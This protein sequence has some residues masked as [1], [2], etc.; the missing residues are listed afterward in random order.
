MQALGF[1]RDHRNENGRTE[2][3]ENKDFP[4]RPQQPSTDDAYEDMDMQDLPNAT[5]AEKKKKGGKKKLG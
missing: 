5:K 3:D 2:N 1:N 4:I